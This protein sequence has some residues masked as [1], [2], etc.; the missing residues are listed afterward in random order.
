MDGTN[1]S[2]FVFNQK[3]ALVLKRFFSVQNQKF[4][5]I[6][7]TEAVV[8]CPFPLHSSLDHFGFNLVVLKGTRVTALKTSPL[9]LQ[10]GR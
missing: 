6:S 5:N 3:V 9:S 1:A 8:F 2:L 10:A 4:L 7:I